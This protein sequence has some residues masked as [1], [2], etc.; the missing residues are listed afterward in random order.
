M[1]RS[2]RV[3]SILFPI[4]LVAHFTCSRLGRAGSEAHDTGENAR[5]T[6]R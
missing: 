6:M 5:D 2:L 1:N 3:S 4:A